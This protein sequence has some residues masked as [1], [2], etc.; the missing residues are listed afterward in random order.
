MDDIIKKVLKKSNRTLFYCLYMLSAKKRRAV[1]AVCA[2]DKI[3]N[4]IADSN[5]PVDKKIE[6]LD[7]WQQE[8]ENV[9]GNSAP[10]SSTGKAL[11]ESFAKFNLPKK[12]FLAV[13]N[14]KR[15]DLLLPPF[16]VSS[17]KYEQ[18]CDNKAGTFVRQLLRI[19]GCRDE[20][21]ID[22]LSDCL[23]KALQTTL[24]LR[25]VKDD[26][27][28]GRIYIPKNYLYNAGISSANPSD[29]IVDNNLGKARGELGKLAG[30]NYIQAFNI[31][32]SFDKKTS[33]RLKAFFYPY[34]YCFDMME[35]RGW[36]VIT[37]KP[38]VSP[39]TKV[40][41]LLKAYMER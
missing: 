32:N 36:E 18:I 1:C 22:Q 5:E 7:A 6:L 21:K 31:I 40:G 4:D 14:D 29:I 28:E 19:L 34:K 10:F 8:I 27:A 15:Q 25:D 3:I 39:L 20:E 30:A 24:F 16:G 33:Q 17:S 12:D 37:P 38:A 41:L 2:F 13:V 26:A 11:F 23:G 35:K 9:Y